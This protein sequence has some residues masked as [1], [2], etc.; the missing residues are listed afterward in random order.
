MSTTPESNP[1]QSPAAASIQESNEDWSEHRGLIRKFRLQIHILG[2][3][4]IFVGVVGGAL[5]VTL[6]LSGISPPMETWEMVAAV[7]AVNGVWTTLGAVACLKQMAGVYLGLGV[8]ILGLL[9]FL[10]VF[11]LWFFLVLLAIIFQAI[12][13]ILLARKLRRLGIPLTAR[14]PNGC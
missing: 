10:I 7:A 4:W 14:V 8:T 13:V 5:I 12:R 2:G 3:I 1:Y 11:N 9:Q 6:A